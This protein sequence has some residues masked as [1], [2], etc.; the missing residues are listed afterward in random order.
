MLRRALSTQRNIP[1]SQL[2]KYL[3]DTINKSSR[4]QLEVQNRQAYIN[5][6]LHEV[7]RDINYMDG[8]LER[9]RSSIQLLS[10]RINM[11]ESKQ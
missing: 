7:Y 6:Q 10:I 9:L 5:N 1:T 3:E 11:L 4:M 2:V 8:E